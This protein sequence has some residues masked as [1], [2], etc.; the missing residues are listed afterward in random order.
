MVLEADV[1]KLC[2]GHPE[3]KVR[4]GQSTANVRLTVCSFGYLGLISEEGVNTAYL[5]ANSTAEAD[6]DWEVGSFGRP[7]PPSGAADRKFSAKERGR[8]VGSALDLQHCLILVKANTR[9]EY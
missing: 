6:R 7:T 9:S 8:C 4:G 1:L 3:R 2:Y 5:P